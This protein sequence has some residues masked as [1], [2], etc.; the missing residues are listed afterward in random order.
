MEKAR[1]S[2]LQ[3]PS[4]CQVGRAAWKA[5]P[6]PFVVTCACWLVG[7]WEKCHF[8]LY[9]RPERASVL[10]G[11]AAL[12]HISGR[13]GRTPCKPSC[14][15]LW[16]CSGCSVTPCKILA[17]RILEQSALIKLGSCLEQDRVPLHTTVHMAGKEFI[18][19]SDDLAF[20]AKCQ[21]RPMFSWGGVLSTTNAQQSAMT[22]VNA[23]W[24]CWGICWQAWWGRIPDATTL[25]FWAM[26]RAAELDLSQLQPIFCPYRNI[27]ETLM[28]CPSR[29]HV[30]G[31][32]L[33]IPAEPIADALTL[34]QISELKHCC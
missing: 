9:F 24:D 2:L 4:Q 6:C 28:L 16:A 12:L 31:R 23:R 26:D 1:V 15:C 17:G 5:L 8:P 14:S 18:I 30:S 33:C 34:P 32:P 13:L 21:E 11:S 3:R 10:M 20:R 25:L 29:C 27:S 7:H 19:M 22:G